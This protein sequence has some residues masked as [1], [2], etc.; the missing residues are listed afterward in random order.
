MILPGVPKSNII[1]DI[2]LFPNQPH[3]MQPITQIIYDN[4]DKIK[5]KKKINAK[6]KFIRSIICHNINGK[7][8]KFDNNSLY[9]DIINHE[10]ASILLLQEVK[11]KNKKIRQFNNY[12]FEIVEG[13]K[14]LYH[15]LPTKFGTSGGL[16]NAIDINLRDQ[17][18]T[19]PYLNPYIQWSID[20]ILNI[21]IANVYIPPNHDNNGKDYNDSILILSDL[22]TQLHHYINIGYEIIIAGD[23]NARIIQFI[24]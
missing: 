1:T 18:Y 9:E 15:T 19:I 17:F 13:R 24:R 5:Q 22:Q 4:K 7:T 21:A 23:F 20:K 12:L 10:K 11:N 6:N 16:I 8:D 14:R 2:E 3:F